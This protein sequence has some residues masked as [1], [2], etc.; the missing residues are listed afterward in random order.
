MDDKADNKKMGAQMTS[1]IRGLTPQ[2]VNS[3]QVA[4]APSMINSP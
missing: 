1:D 4:K 2:S 3:D